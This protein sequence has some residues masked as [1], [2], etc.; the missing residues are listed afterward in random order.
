MKIKIVLSLLLAVLIFRSSATYAQTRDLNYGMNYQAVIRDSDG[1]LIANEEIIMRFEYYNNTDT[2]FVYAESFTITTDQFGMVNLLLET[3]TPDSGYYPWNIDF[4]HT[5]VIL[6]IFVNGLEMGE[7]MFREVPYAKKA[8]YAEALLNPAIDGHPDVTIDGPS[9][10][11]GCLLV[12]NWGTYWTNDTTLRVRNDK[13]GIGVY[14]AEEKLHVNGNIKV[15][16]EINRQQ[17]G[18]ANVMPIAYGMINADGTVSTTNS[19]TNI[20]ATREGTGIYHVTIADETYTYFG[21]V[22]SLTTLTEGTIASAGSVSGK[23]IVKLVDHT[24]AAVDGRVY[25]VIYKL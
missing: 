21:F 5:E 4:V 7:M 8:Q 12:F 20:S 3:G 14:D 6:K 2:E 1:N 22:P 15:E 17:T 10:T 19:T 24:G 9:L 18:Q 16:G 11:D 13:V 25:F 23:M